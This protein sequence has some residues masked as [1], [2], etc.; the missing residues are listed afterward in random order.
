MSSIPVFD[1]EEDITEIVGKILPG[2]KIL[3][4]KGFSIKNFSKDYNEAKT[5][6]G[7]EWTYLNSESEITRWLTFNGWIGVVIPEGYI[8]IDVDDSNSGSL[9]KTL[10]DKEGICHHCIKTPRGFQFVFK[11]N[12]EDTRLVKQISKFFTQIGVSIDTRV[13]TT[14]GYI[15]FPTH[16]T[17]N[18]YILSQSE[19]L[20][21][22]PFF[23]RPIRR[24]KDD[25]EF[26]IPVQNG[27]RD[28]NLYHFAARLN[29]WR[30][31]KEDAEKSMKLIYEYFVLDKTDFPEKQLK[32]IINSAYKWK[33]ERN[34]PFKNGVEDWQAALECDKYGRP[35]CNA[36]NTELIIENTIGDIRFNEF[37]VECE[38][39]G[40]LQWR[41]GEEKVWL[42]SDYNQLEHWFATQWNFKGRNMIH[43]AFIHVVRKRWYH[44]VKEYIESAEWDGEIRVPTFFCDYL[45]AECSIYTQEVTK[46]W[47]TGAVKRTYEPGCKFE[48]VP[49]L[50]GEK[51]IGKSVI[52]SK[53][54]NEKWFTDSIRSLEPKIAG[55]IL[56]NVWICEFPE[57]KAF[58]GKSDEEV[59][60]FISSC[61]DIYRGAYERGKATSHK[62]HTVFY[63]SS[64]KNEVLTD[65]TGERR[66]FPI[67]CSKVRKYNPFTDL[68]PE[69]V[70]QIW[71]EAK[72]YYDQ[73]YFTY[74]DAEIQEQ[75]EEVFKNFKDVDPLEGEID[76]YVKERGEVCVRQ[77]W[78]EIMTEDL[79]KKPTRKDSNRII[80]ILTSLGYEHVG[81]K[82]IEKYGNSNQRIFGSKN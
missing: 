53:L 26:P 30:I 31:P 72:V 23:L 55:E 39:H 74:I 56:A 40:D 27:S 69:I 38:V 37:T 65:E 45:G 36:R 48:I 15:V 76:E 10:L 3:K 9:L 81:W 58:N 33:P 66:R 20:Y 35:L 43:N 61:D 19:E 21:E 22:L 34:S 11:A 68:T 17:E 6:V 71:A 75:A 12:E 4:L 13:G 51:G 77:I 28:D 54:A 32:K 24:K 2:A 16:N 78:D 25:Y 52:G 7:R 80:S 1:S 50:I 63:G 64:N 18:R 47:F 14:N 59:K 44:P 5:P 70:A 73:G 79:K 82:R 46:R 41:N 49:V 67:K 29:A 60:A 8:V 57:L 42:S 62:R